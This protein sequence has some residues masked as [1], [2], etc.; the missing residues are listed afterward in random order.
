MKLVYRG[1]GYEAKVERARP[2]SGSDPFLK[3][4]NNSY[5]DGLL[6][7]LTGGEWG[8]PFDSAD[9]RNWRE[10][11]QQ[12]NRI[13]DLSMA[14]EY[15]RS[16][17]QTLVNN[18]VGEG[19][20]LQVRVPRVRGEGID[21]DLSNRIENEFKEWCRKENCDMRRKHSFA[22]MCRAAMF[23]VAGP[24][25]AFFR[26]W[27][28][29]PNNSESAIQFALQAIESHQ[30]D[31]GWSG[32]LRSGNKQ[33]RMGVELDEFEAPVAYWVLPEHPAHSG[34]WGGR[35]SSRFKPV[36]VPA[37]EIVHIFPQ[38]EE[39]PGMTRGF[40]LLVASLGTL[41]EIKQYEWT[42]Q[43]KARIQ[44]CITFVRN[45][46][47]LPQ[48]LINS[49]SE[50]KRNNQY[51]PAKVKLEPGV[52]PLLY[53]EDITPFTPTSPNPHLVAFDELLLRRVCTGIGLPYQSVAKK[54]SDVNYSSGRLAM[55]DAQV[56]YRIFQA[57]LIQEFCQVV[58]ERWLEQAVLSGVLPLDDYFLRPERYR[59]AARWRAPGWV[60]TDPKADIA[61]AIMGTQHGL[62]TWT[63][64][65]G[66]QGHDPE[67]WIEAWTTEKALVEAKKDEDLRRI[68]MSWYEG[69]NA[70]VVREVEGQ[71]GE[72]SPQARS[73]DDFVLVV[74]NGN[75]RGKQ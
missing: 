75:G 51:N 19:I 3:A 23:S 10:L 70:A 2:D 8:A 32:Y 34:N 25:E 58:Y 52:A 6:G 11:Y 26:L 68:W 66:K 43:I 67:D 50:G 46:K 38:D 71:T 4:G 16:A 20:R 17:K 31:D 74:P 54:F 1:V 47:E 22:R 13:L 64:E 53:G 5:A 57:W 24:G 60:W 27:N 56:V 41:K 61:A 49:R 62:T 40:P 55:I 9:S 36:R 72:Q 21:Q 45:L 59:S 65:L 15:T 7:R 48:E 39:R 12:R 28:R 63:W 37:E 73:M 35:R 69:E 30:V 33:V 42:E 44:T 14:D 29:V 18:V